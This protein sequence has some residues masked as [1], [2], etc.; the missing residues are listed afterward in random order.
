[1]WGQVEAATV[2]VDRMHEV[3]PVPKAP[4]RVL[5]PLDLGIDR[6]AGRRPAPQI[7]TFDYYIDNPGP[8]ASRED[9]GPLSFDVI[10]DGGLSVN[11]FTTASCS[12]YYFAA[13]IMDA[14]GKTGMSGITSPPVEPVPEPA[15]IFLLGTVGLGVLVSLRRHGR[16]TGR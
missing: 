15:S 2:E 9:A 7:G 1:L 3:L 4:R 13:D 11:S 6:F 14:D 10:L 12:K 16:A 8:G 5:H